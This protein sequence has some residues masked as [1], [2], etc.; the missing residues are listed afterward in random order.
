MSETRNPAWANV[1][2]VQISAKVPPPPSRYPKAGILPVPA[3]VQIGI[4][5]VVVVI[6]IGAAAVAAQEAHIVDQRSSPALHSTAT[7]RGLMPPVKTPKPLM[8]FVP[9]G[10]AEITARGAPTP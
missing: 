10:G 8:I 4:G 6:R 2:G 5:G 3:L 7:A 1:S 9:P